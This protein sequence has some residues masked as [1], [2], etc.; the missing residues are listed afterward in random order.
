MSFEHK[1]SK[2]ESDNPEPNH[3]PT[4]ISNKQVDFDAEADRL[5]GEANKGELS[6]DPEVQEYLDDENTELPS[7]LGEEGVILEESYDNPKLN[8]T[9]ALSETHIDRAKE[10]A[11]DSPDNGANFTDHNEKHWIEVEEKTSET[12]DAVETSVESGKIYPED[13]VDDGNRVKFGSDIDRDVL[14]AAALSH[15]TGMSDDGYSLNSKD[16]TL[17]CEKQDPTNFESYDKFFDSVRS[18][19]SLNSALNVLENRDKYAE[20]GFNDEQIDSIAV[21]CMTHSKS[22]SGLRDLN[23]KEDWGNC[24]DRMDQAVEKYNHDHPDN[25]ITFDRKSF[26]DNPE[27]LSNLASSALCLRVGDVSRDSGPDSLTQSGETVHVEMN[28]NPVKAT[29]WKEETKNF[30]V[31]RSDGAEVDSEKS[32]Q[33]HIG[34]QNITESHTNINEDGIVE[35]TIKVH[36]GDYAP[37]CTMEAIKDHLGEF[38]SAKDGHFVITVE[39]DKPCG[40]MQ[41]EYSNWRRDLEEKPD[42]KTGDLYCPNIDIQFPW[43][44]EG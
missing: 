4:D 20:M 21:L 16:G 36:D 10:I 24:F 6:G 23:S 2:I 44:K 7:G 30:T 34:E 42:K 13:F 27:A 35:H 14:S 37:H 15:D 31:T 22:N 12:A 19:H 39:F 33:V 26:E 9:L 5:T 38:A 11:K 25:Q 43:D 18:N 28:D 1:S 32:K 17:V 41:T 40:E 3:R 8:K 29:D